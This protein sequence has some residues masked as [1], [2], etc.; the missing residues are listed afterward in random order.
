MTASGLDMALQLVY[1]AF[2]ANE[3]VPD[4][5]SASVWRAK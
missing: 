3:Q 1:S 4:H 5:T 2:P